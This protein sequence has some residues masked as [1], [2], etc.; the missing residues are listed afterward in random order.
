MN[1]NEINWDFNE[2]GEWPLSIRIAAIVLAALLVVGVAVYY[3]TMPQFEQLEADQR[4]EGDLKRQFEVKQ[5]KA[6]NLEA[7]KQQ[8][9]QIELSL[10]EMIKLMPTKA[11][12]ASLLIDISQTGMASGLEFRLFRPGKPIRRDFYYELPI[13]IQVVGDYEE[14]GLFVSG[15]AAL[16]RIV[17]IHD[18]KITP[19][20]GDK[21]ASNALVMDAT[22]KTYNEADQ[23]AQKP[24]PKRGR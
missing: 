5:K 21:Q 3:D 14:L 18:V 15:L 20:T 23:P 16:P 6:A 22:I 19:R 24:K 17:T 13:A 2:A 1:L 11:E 10:A 8:L 7:Y 9:A 12:V 4:K